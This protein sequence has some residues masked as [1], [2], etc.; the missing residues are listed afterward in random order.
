MTKT[1]FEKSKTNIDGIRLTNEAH[2]F[3]FINSNSS[4]WRNADKL[5][6]EI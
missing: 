1:I 5:E 3:D 2:N 4:S 6:L